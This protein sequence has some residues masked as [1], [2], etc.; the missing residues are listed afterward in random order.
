MKNP[1]SN[2]TIA[3]ARAL[4]RNMTDAERKL[5]QH[6]R[7]R[8]TG[9]CKFRRQVPIGPYIVD[10]ICFEKGLI[11]EL[12]GGQ[13][14]EQEEYDA[15]RTKWLQSRGYRVLRFWNNDVMTDV[16]VVKEEIYRN[17]ISPSP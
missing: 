14:A 12:D 16:E 6:L 17:L 7:D 2:T 13:H 4:R 5:W 1:A 11:V 10:F 9:S 3:N 15:E 8:Q